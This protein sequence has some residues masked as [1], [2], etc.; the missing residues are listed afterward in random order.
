MGMM[1]NRHKKSK[2]KTEE[3]KSGNGPIPVKK[4]PG[5]PRKV[6]HGVN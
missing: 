1:I 3:K 2:K 4:R 6:K 5:R